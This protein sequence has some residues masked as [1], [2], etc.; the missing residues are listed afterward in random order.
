MKFIK[1][2]EKSMNLITGKI[3]VIE[4]ALSVNKNFIN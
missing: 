4:E 3:K 1:F 2:S